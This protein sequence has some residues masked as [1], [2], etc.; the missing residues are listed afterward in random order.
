MFAE[1][2]LA[3]MMQ[4]GPVGAAETAAYT[5]IDSLAEN[6]TSAAWCDRIGYTVDARLPE[7]ANQAALVEAG[8]RGIDQER[9]LGWARDG[10]NRHI[11]LMESEFDQAI[12]RMDDDDDQGAEAIKQVMNR[13]ATKCAEAAVDPALAGMIT[14]TN[15]ADLAAART[16][17]VDGLL[18][19]LG[20]ASWQTPKIFAQAEV[21]YA[22]G[23]CKG[24]ISGAR[25]DELFRRHLDA[26]SV[27]QR[28]ERYLSGQYAEGLEQAAELDLDDTQCRRLLS[29]RESALAR[30]SR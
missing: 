19:P 17:F 21:L 22:V 23:A 8:S 24:R 16:V 1:I 27:D 25:H 14:F 15:A 9:A 7:V 6:V 4:S 30:A 18:E 13:R 11:A 29:S 10:F 20:Q 26:S 3:L 12:K 5:R 28:T 2:A